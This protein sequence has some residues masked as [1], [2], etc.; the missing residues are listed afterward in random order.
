MNKR[1]PLVLVEDDADDQEMI[2]LALES[3]GL[4]KHTK[5]FHEPESALNFLYESDVKPF[6]IISDMNMPKMDGLK[7]KE[8][9]ESCRILKDKRIP[10]VFLSTASSESCI[11]RAYDLRVQGFFEKGKSFDDLKKSLNTIL[12]YWN[13][14]KLSN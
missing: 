4:A 11:N 7:F 9:I 1:G 12:E 13:K 8:T 5:I 3:L 14:C 6:L 10:F 2:V